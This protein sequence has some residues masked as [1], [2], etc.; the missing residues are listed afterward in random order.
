MLTM[1]MGKILSWAHALILFASLTLASRAEAQRPGPL[2]LWPQITQ[3]IYNHSNVLVMNCEVAPDGLTVTD[4]AWDAYKVEGCGKRWTVNM[5]L[6]MEGPLK[7]YR[8]G[9]EFSGLPVNITVEFFNPARPWEVKEN[10]QEILLLGGKQT[11]LLPHWFHVPTNR[12]AYDFDEGGAFPSG[13]SLPRGKYALWQGAAK[14]RQQD[15]NGRCPM[16]DFGFTHVAPCAMTPNGNQGSRD[17][18]ALLFGD[19]E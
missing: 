19:N 4:M 2:K 15:R 7:D 9:P 6:P 16:Y 17:R 1:G 10:Y 12:F 11:I 18:R 8:F 14:A 5:G 3:G 13:W